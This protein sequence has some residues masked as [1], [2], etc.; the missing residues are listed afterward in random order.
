LSKSDYI[1]EADAICTAS[2]AKIEA[3]VGTAL[4]GGEPTPEQLQTAADEIVLVVCDGEQD[5]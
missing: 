5:A 2:N 1:V 4:A 3:A